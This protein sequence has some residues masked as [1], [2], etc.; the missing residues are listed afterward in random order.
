MRERKTE[1][2]RERGREKERGRDRGIK[3]LIRCPGPGYVELYSQATIV[4]AGT[5]VPRV[6]H[7]YSAR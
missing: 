2:E 6:R 3:T 4:P 7:L 1:R 5:I